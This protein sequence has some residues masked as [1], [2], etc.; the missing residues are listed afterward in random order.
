MLIDEAAYR[1]MQRALEPAKTAGGTIHGGRRVAVKGAADPFYLRPALVEIAAQ[2][3]PVEHETFAL[4]L[5]VMKYS[6]F[7]SVLGLHKAVCPIFSNDL[8]G[9]ET[10]LS[11]VG[12]LRH[13]RRQYRHI[14]RRKS[15]RDRGRESD[16]WR[17][18]LRVPRVECL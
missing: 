4:M 10:F 14:G 9:E 1:G 5:Y 17:A 13:R 15:L 7:E 2:T 18:G 12:R 16:R 3:A 6:C 11:R 8:R